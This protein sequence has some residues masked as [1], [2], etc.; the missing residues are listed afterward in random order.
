MLYTFFS[1]FVLFF[2][3]ILLI[4]LGKSRSD[5]KAQKMSE[6]FWQKELSANQTRKQSLEHLNYIHIPLAS[7]PF[8]HTE[9]EELTKLEQK[10]EALS[11]EKIVNLTGISNTD[12]KA[13]Y[14]AANLDTLTLYDSRFTELARTIYLWGQRLAELG[15]LS[16]AVC[17]LEFGVN[18]KSDVCSAYMLLA[19]LYS[20]TGREDKIKHLLT[21]CRSMNT[22][23][24]RTIEK[25]LLQSYHIEE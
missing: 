5:K 3:V 10:I 19:S 17:V 7:L 1:Y 12:L 4:H 15:Y 21:V 6:A 16:E 24:G 22:L 14:G 18:I 25:K 23:S 9:D 13:A 2:I 11:K 8:L 20:Q